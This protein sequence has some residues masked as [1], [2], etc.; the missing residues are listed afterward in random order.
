MP[1]LVEI[2]PGN[3]RILL[4]TDDVKNI[5]PIGNLP[6]I[7]VPGIFVPVV[8]EKQCVYE[9]PFRCVMGVT[10]DNKRILFLCFKKDLLIIPRSRNEFF[11]IH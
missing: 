10:R 11:Y 6:R 2:A 4:Q 9:T 1:D 3:V 5:V 8:P 7:N